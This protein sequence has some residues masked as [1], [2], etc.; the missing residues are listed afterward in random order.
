MHIHRFGDDTEKVEGNSGCGRYGNS[1]LVR[2][3]DG[4]NFGGADRSRGSLLL[5][6]LLKHFHQSADLLTLL[7]QFLMDLLHLRLRLGLRLGFESEK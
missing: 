7:E 6:P 3:L 2:S 4:P 1:F 5:F